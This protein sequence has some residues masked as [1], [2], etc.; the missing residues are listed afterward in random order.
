MKNLCYALAALAAIALAL[1]SIASAED[2]KPMAMP[3]KH[4]HHH[5]HHHHH[6]MMKKP[7]TDEKK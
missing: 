5:H 3:M 6:E 7:M 2:A 4:H 1:P